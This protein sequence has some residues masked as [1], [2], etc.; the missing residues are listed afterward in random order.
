VV[1]AAK[2]DQSG[3]ATLKSLVAEFPSSDVS[4]NLFISAKTLKSILDFPQSHA[5]LREPAPESAQ[6]QVSCGS[7]DFRQGSNRESVY[8]PIYPSGCPNLVPQASGYCPDFIVA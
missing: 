6:T 5:A 3:G 1:A 4:V 2:E 7:H 8:P